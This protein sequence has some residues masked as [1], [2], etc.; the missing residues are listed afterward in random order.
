MRPRYIYPAEVSTHPSRSPLSPLSLPI[1]SSDWLKD[2]HSLLTCFHSPT[3]PSPVHHRPASIRASGGNR[4]LST[5]FTSCA[6][7]SMNHI[8]GGGS[9]LGTLVSLI[10]AVCRLTELLP[11]RQEGFNVQLSDVS[12][13]NNRFM[14]HHWIHHQWIHHLL[15]V[16]TVKSK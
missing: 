6:T 7:T 15:C 16:L 12:W 14:I 5:V 1:N 10:A 4:I 8:C 3:F 9:S 11:Q 2:L 13:F